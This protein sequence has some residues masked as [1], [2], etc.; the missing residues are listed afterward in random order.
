MVKSV[1]VGQHY[2]KKATTYEAAYT[3]D[4][5]LLAN[6]LR[7]LH[8]CLLIQR[9]GFLAVIMNSTSLPFN[10]FDLTCMLLLKVEK[11]RTART[12]ADSH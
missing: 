10:N 2:L 7:S 11:L 5:L 9:G 6:N 1:R 3:Q 8:V 12:D 4:S